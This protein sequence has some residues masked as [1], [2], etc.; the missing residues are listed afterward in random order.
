MVRLIPKSYHV[1]ALIN[2]MIFKPVVFE[3][4]SKEYK[5]NTF[6]L[7]RFFKKELKKREENQIESHKRNN[8]KFAA[9]N[10]HLPKKIL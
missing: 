5:R 10:A 4:L 8:V 7:K 2:R 9:F 1:E 3:Y 6:S